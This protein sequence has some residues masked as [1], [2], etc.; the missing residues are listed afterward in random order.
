MTTRRDFLVRSAALGC[1]AAASPLVTPVVLASAPGEARLVVIVLRGGLDGL[2]AVAPVGDPGF[3]ALGRDLAG[4]AQ[5]L[6]GF[7]ALHPALAPLLPLWR[8]GE[9]GFAHAVATPY[10]GKRSHFDGQDFLENGGNAADGSMTEAADGWLN[11]LLGL[12]GAPGAETA[13]SVGREQLRLLSGE[14]LHS[15]WSPEARLGLSPQGEALLDLIYRKDP[16]FAR[17]AAQAIALSESMGEGRLSPAKAT[18]AEA[19]ARFAASR[20]NGETRI[21]AFSLS[22]FDTH[23]NQSSLLKRSL[24]ELTSAITTLRDEL[25]GNW[26]RTAVMAMTEFGRTA[27]INGSSGT[28]HG[29]GGLLIYAG[30]AVRGGQVLGRWPGLAEADLYQRRDLMPTDDLR[31]YAGWVLRDLFGAPKAGIETQIFP[32]LSLEAN[33]GIIA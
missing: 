21:A 15:S 23:K 19:L 32:G 28:D 16:L 18:R 1:S 33:P 7:Y 24:G 6:N 4:G 11:R 14:A 30:G 9:L 13:F 31:R 5:D 29:T 12:I 25:G 10:R 27:R 8:A 22:G 3:A 26:A 20:L 17:A 2:D